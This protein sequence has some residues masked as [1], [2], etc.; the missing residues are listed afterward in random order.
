M[1]RTIPAPRPVIEAEIRRLMKV[2]NAL[3]DPGDREIAKKLLKCASRSTDAYRFV[4]LSDPLEAVLIGIMICL[5]RECVWR[6]TS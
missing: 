6:D 1:G 3:K 5:A 2:A 4:P